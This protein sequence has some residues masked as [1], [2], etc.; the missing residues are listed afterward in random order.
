MVFVG[1]SPERQGYKLYDPATRNVVYSRDVI[2]DETRF[3]KEQQTTN[4]EVIFFP[5]KEEKTY[6]E[7]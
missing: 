1:Y 5:T 4:D 7:I 2:F 6:D 3:Y